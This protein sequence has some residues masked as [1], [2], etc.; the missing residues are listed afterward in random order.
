VDIRIEIVGAKVRLFDDT[1]LS[2]PCNQIQSITNASALEELLD[3][4]T[5]IFMSSVS[6]LALSRMLYAE[7]MRDKIVKEIYE[8]LTKVFKIADKK[9]I[10][11]KEKLRSLEDRLANQIVIKKGGVNKGDSSEQMRPKQVIPPFRDKGQT[12]DTNDTNIDDHS[13]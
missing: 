4:E 11:I 1:M 7:D 2:K 5:E 13:A 8:H 6:M 12:Y 10:V 3:F 9:D